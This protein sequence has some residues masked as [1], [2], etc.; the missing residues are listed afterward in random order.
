MKDLARC[1]FCGFEDGEVGYLPGGGGYY[2]VHC[3]C[4]ECRGPT[5]PT[6]DRAVNAWNKLNE[7]L[8]AY[9]DRLEDKTA[10]DDESLEKLFGRPIFLRSV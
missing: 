1:P 9:I 8:M 7:E 4:C 2:Y 6:Q 3:N 5:C 10:Y